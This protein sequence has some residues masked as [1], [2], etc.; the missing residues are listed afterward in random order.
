MQGTVTE[1]ETPPQSEEKLRGLFLG[2]IIFRQS[3]ISVP[4]LSFWNSMQLSWESGIDMLEKHKF[5]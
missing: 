3:Q 1:A 5:L 2:G 4:I